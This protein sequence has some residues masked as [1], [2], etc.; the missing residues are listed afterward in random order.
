MALKRR[1][2][3]RQFLTTAASAMGVSL[4][5]ACGATPT[6][7]PAPTQTPVIV[8][9]TVT[10]IQTQVVEKQVPVTQ[11]VPVTQIVEK[12]ITATPAPKGAI[13]QLS[14]TLS[15]AKYADAPNKDG[16]KSPGQIVWDS[17]FNAY[18]QV[19]PNVKVD[20]VTFPE[21][22]S[23]DD[24]Y[25]W[26]KT[27]Q[28][29]KNTP[30]L[31]NSTVDQVTPVQEAQGTSPWVAI[32]SYLAE[33]NP[34][35]GNIWKDDQD[36]NLLR[37]RSSLQGRKYIYGM[38][39][40]RYKAAWMYNKTMFAKLGLKEP[41]TWSEWFAVNDKLKAAGI[42]PI[43]RPGGA[44]YWGHTAWILFGALG[45][46]AWNDLAGPGND[47]PPLQRQL[48]Y[49]MCGKYTVDKPWV[50]EGY[51]AIKKLTSYCPDGFMGMTADQTNQMFMQGKAAMMYVD[52]GYLST[53]DAAKAA[54]TIDFDIECFPT[55]KLD[56]GVF[57]KPVLA[58]A[59]PIAD[60]GE[61]YG[62]WLISAAN[63]RADKSESQVKLGVDF[64]RFLTKPD[65]QSIFV[66]NLLNLP[67]NPSVKFKDP[68]VAS[69]M[70]NP[71]QISYKWLFYGDRPTWYQYFQAYIGGQMTL[72]QFVATAGDELKKFETTVAK[73]SNITIK[74]S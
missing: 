45:R 35:T 39:P 62:I 72:D 15:I 9:Q 69:W 65:V 57:S 28:S 42:A 48:E 70:K 54:K 63:V 74:C 17:I 8:K 33:V 34:Y 19:Q 58:E 52:Q 13:E 47:Y 38:T 68:R 71:E 31:V 56:E 10:V 1:V 30:T 66:D 23:P 7:T 25:Q 4:L 11:V 3:R 36:Y 18:K 16:S 32:D 22:A 6:P 64:L 60:D 12:V 20:V 46:T 21:G 53:I 59:G 61:N 67:T 73:E 50:R 37:W 5:A 44:F 51:Q 40:T 29:A 43:A 26:V 49:V 14:G 41:T 2:T 24:V 55:P 27:R